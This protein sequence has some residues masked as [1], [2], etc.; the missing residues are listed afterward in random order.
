MKFRDCLQKYAQQA[1]FV[2]SEAQVTQLEQYYEL[3]IETNKVMNL[4]AITEVREVVLK[5]ILDSFYAYEPEIFNSGAK[6]CDLGTGAGFPGVPLKVL[7]PKLD[8]VLMD[9][10]AKRLKF[11]D[12]VIENLGL[13]QIVTCHLRAEDAGRSK[14]HREQYDLVCSR[15]VARLQIL[16]EYCLPLLQTGGVFV[17]MKAS[18]YQLEVEQAE[19][20][21][22]ILGGKIIKIKQVQLPELEDK[23]V[24]IYIKKER[25]TASVFTRSSS[26]SQ[27]HSSA[28]L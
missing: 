2:L 25:S 8:V 20:A 22:K 28:S 16:A 3:L 4:T 21:L 23:R 18:N 17:A 26:C 10:L 1:G 9:S 19:A 14:Q 5:H 12:Q 13:Q 7:Q 15:A 27:L 24:V 6:I 11:L